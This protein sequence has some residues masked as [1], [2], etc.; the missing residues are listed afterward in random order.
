MK[1]LKVR[2]LLAGFWLRRWRLSLIALGIGAAGTA[3]VFALPAEYRA[4]AIVAFRAE[5]PSADLVLPAV[6]TLPEDRLKALHAELLADPLLRRVVDE[7]HLFP[8]VKTEDARVAQLRGQLEVKL[9]GDNVFEL[10][11][12]SRDPGLAASE[13]NRLWALYAEQVRNQRLEAARRVADVFGP[14]LVDLRSKLQGQDGAIA[15]FKASHL[16]DL[17]EELDGNLRGYDRVSLLRERDVEALMDA[18]RR[19][20]S[21]VQAGHDDATALGRLRRHREELSKELTE[22]RSQ[23]TEEH[24]E[25]QRLERELVLIDGQI[26][27]SQS[28]QTDGTLELKAVERQIAEL[29]ADEGRLDGQADGLR[30]RVDGTPVVAED[31]GR[32]QRSR[33]AIQAK[34][35]AL[36]GRQVEAEL[37]AD[38]EERQLP[39][40]FRVVAP[41][42]VPSQP[43]KPD[44]AA[45]LVLVWLAA[46]ALSALTGAALE[47]ADDSIRDAA[48]ARERLGVPVLAVV[49]RFPRAQLGKTNAR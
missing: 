21:L 18:E 37:S 13:A 42:S 47:L 46:L 15:R 23:W 5:H 12:T 16:G 41:A 20:T 32:L 7:L 44:R 22:A 43:A 9:D 19:R 8:G 30:K 45:G 27:T 34:Y 10:E 48:D 6:S 29:Q 26:K 4:T 25:V 17:P 28:A 14:E 11:V 49:P 1:N 38:L 31:L 3:L 2:E 35:Q 36:L 33:D 39:D 40:L 24:P